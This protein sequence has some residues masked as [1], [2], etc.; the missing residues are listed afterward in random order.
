MLRTFHFVA[1]V[2]LTVFISCAFGGCAHMQQKRNSVN[3]AITIADI[4]E[5]QVLD[6]L[7]RFT[8]NPYATPA[9]SIASQ[10]TNGVTDHGE[11]GLSD[12]AFTGKFFGFLSSNAARD[13]ELNM[14]Q[15][16]VKDPRRLRLM[17]CA[18]QT[19]LGIS[20]DDCQNCCKLL[21]EWKGDKAACWDQCGITCGWVCK[22]NSRKD[23]P[24]C[25]CENYGVFCGTYVWVNPA[26]RNEFSKLVMTIIDFAAGDPAPDPNPVKATY[27]F[28]ADGKPAVMGQHV[29]EAEA[30]VSREE[31]N[32]QL[33]DAF[34]IPKLKEE[35]SRNETA[36]KV[37]K[38]TPEAR[39]E[40]ERLQTE[41]QR[42]QQ[43]AI[44]TLVAPPN[45]GERA[46]SSLNYQNDL[47]RTRQLLN[48]VPGR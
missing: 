32:K 15:D 1:T 10:A 6:N 46:G 4:Y 17:Q 28:G 21:G 34:Q 14:T 47:L 39:R 19:A 22:S 3:Q 41:L 16:A 43:P 35:I 37:A 40:I 30:Y 42:L 2:T 23:I 11:F 5:K 12:G 36:L 45:F 44:P 27:Y 48:T 31:F 8:V 18:Y 24:K 20:I 7:A 33:A 9:F 38:D 26:Y 13:N 25:C 29:K